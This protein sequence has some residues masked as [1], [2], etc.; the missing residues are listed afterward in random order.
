VINTTVALI[1]LLVFSFLI[2]YLL[3]KVTA[4]GTLLG[5]IEF[6]IIGVFLGTNAGIGVLTE[7]MISAL[8]PFIYLILGLTG[9]FFGL[10]TSNLKFKDEITQTGIWT[11]LS[12]FVAVGLFVFYVGVVVFPDDLSKYHLIVGREEFEFLG[13]SFRFTATED[14]LWLAIVLAAAA[15]ISSSET[16]KL[17][18]KK[19]RAA[20]PVSTALAKLSPPSEILGI[21]I[22]GLSLAAARAIES[23]AQLGMT[24]VEWT[25][26]VVGLGCLCGFLFSLFIG[27]KEDDL[28][29]YLATVGIVTFAS[30]IGSA[31]GVSSL[32]VNFICGVVLSWTSPFSGRMYEILEKLRNPL[33]IMLLLFAGIAW[34]PPSS[35]LLWI[36]PAAFILVRILAISLSGRVITAVSLSENLGAPR[37][38]QGLIGQDALIVAI[39]VDFCVRYKDYSQIVMTT[40]LSTFIVNELISSKLLKKLLSDSCEITSVNEKQVTG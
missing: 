25:I 20:G 35:P 13:Q 7:Q 17:N 36:F 28:R 6:T 14:H 27:K 24:V 40:I 15:T 34:I 37:V 8:N 18:I 38:G 10:S 16:V 1:I 19:F 5:G 11:S 29:V 26:A 32:F 12:V 4:K 33:S 30:G 9:F 39:G 3:K 22:F 21:L 31:L 23:S 2:N